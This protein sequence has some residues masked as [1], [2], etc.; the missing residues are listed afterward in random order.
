MIVEPLHAN[1]VVHVLAADERTKGGL[2]VPEI[3][4]N[5]HFARAEVLAAGPGH[6]NMDGRVFPLGVK[7]GDVV[8]VQRQQLVMFPHPAYPDDES[9]G[10]CPE[11]A[12]LGVVRG[13]E[14]GTG[15]VGQDGREVTVPADHGGGIAVVDHTGTAAE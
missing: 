6:R 9:V 5:K 3:A 10:I 4:R 14:R 8:M 15:I 13:L 1:V 2:I 12:I 11:N 7:A